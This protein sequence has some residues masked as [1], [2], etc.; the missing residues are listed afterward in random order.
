[1]KKYILAISLFALFNSI[2]YANTVTQ[3]DPCASMSLTAPEIDP[4]TGYS[5]N[6]NGRN[7]SGRAYTAS[8]YVDDQRSST[9]SNYSFFN[10]NFGPF[11][12]GHTFKLVF[13]NIDRM[14]YCKRSIEITVKEISPRDMA[15]GICSSIEA[16]PNNTF[17]NNAPQH[18]KAFCSKTTEV[19]N[20]ITSAEG[21]SSSYDASQY[22][23]TAIDKLKNDIGAKMDSAAGG[24]PNNDWITDELSQKLIYKRVTD[25]I[26]V[27]EKRK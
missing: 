6:A 19:I 23:Q 3:S 21:S 22:Y 4:G 9:D 15:A 2:A 24:Q 7:N 18:K 16:L 12:G 1:M 27:L 26:S 5:V 14:S 8:F 17:K 11:K 20:L 13:E 10:K 25:L